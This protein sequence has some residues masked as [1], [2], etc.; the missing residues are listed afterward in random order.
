MPQGFK[1]QLCVFCGVRLSTR[2]G[3][4]VLARSL[5]TVA[6]TYRRSLLALSAMGEKSRLEHY[7][8]TVLPF[9][10]RHVDASANLEQLVPRRL[11][12]NARLQREIGEGRETAEITNEDGKAATGTTSIPIRG[13]ALFD[14]VLP[15]SVHD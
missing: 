9:G 13:E 14:C 1:G 4:H 15:V 7:L 2:T 6:E 5:N 11:E 8:A 10:G 12:K 3:D